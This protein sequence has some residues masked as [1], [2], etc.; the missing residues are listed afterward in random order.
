MSTLTKIAKQVGK[1][2]K[3]AGMTKPATLTLVSPGTRTPGAVS[4]GTNATSTNYSARGLVTSYQAREID[5][6]IVQVNDKWNIGAGKPFPS[7]GCQI[8]IEG[9]T[10]RVISVD[11]DA[12]AATYVCQSR[13]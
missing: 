6:T 13:K 2:M 8:T 1:A 4:G 10:Y 5:G 12:A 9:A 3:K 11:R 7:A